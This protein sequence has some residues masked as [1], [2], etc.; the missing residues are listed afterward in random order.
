MP[1]TVEKTLQMVPGLSSLARST[2][3]R[4]WFVC[5]LPSLVMSF[6]ARSRSSTRLWWMEC[7]WNSKQTSLTSVCA[8]ERRRVAWLARKCNSSR[9]RGCLPVACGK[10]WC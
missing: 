3:T 5:E 4:S 2:A 10:L 9:L 6:T 8:P 7:P 1:L